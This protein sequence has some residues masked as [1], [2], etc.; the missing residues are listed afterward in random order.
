MNFCEFFKILLFF[1][2]L[3]SGKIKELTLNAFLIYM[4][5]LLILIGLP[6][7][8]PEKAGMGTPFE[9]KDRTQRAGLA[10]RIEKAR[11]MEEHMKKKIIIIII[12]KIYTINV[13]KLITKIKLEQILQLKF[14]FSLRIY[15]NMIFA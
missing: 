15:H 13:I 7:F 11:L 14:S 6:D 3:I 1:F 9:E 8:A 5:S 12:Q 4:A 2:L 10:L